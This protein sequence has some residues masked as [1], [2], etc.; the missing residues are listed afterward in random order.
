MLTP[1]RLAA[2]RATLKRCPFCDDGADVVETEV[3]EG[4]RWF[5]ECH[6][7]DGEGAVGYEPCCGEGSVP[8]WATPEEAARAWNR[9]A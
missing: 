6:T 4:S 7:S 8:T 2:I 9:R 5:V 3:G 1:E